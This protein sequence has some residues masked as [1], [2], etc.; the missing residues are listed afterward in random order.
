M[1]YL[2]SPKASL[3]ADLG[4]HLW[5]LGGAFLGLVSHSGG[6]VLQH[7][8]RHRPFPSALKVLQLQGLTL[9]SLKAFYSWLSVLLLGLPAIRCWAFMTKPNSTTFLPTSCLLVSLL[10]SFS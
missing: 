6:A 8:S 9:L 4:A 1:W 5:V 10:A 7:R 3:V 2:V